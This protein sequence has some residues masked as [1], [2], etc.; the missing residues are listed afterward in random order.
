MNFDIDALMNNALI[1]VP[2]VTMIVQAIKLSF[3]KEKNFKWCP[4]I[5]IGVGILIA[6]LG[7]NNVDG[8]DLRHILG[9]GVFSGLASSGIYSGLK[10]SMYGDKEEHID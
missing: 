2:V 6:W 3:L 10:A 4:I 1:I 5:A 8:V 7:A 9:V